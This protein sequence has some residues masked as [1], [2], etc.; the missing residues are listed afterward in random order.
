MLFDP[1]AR[2]TLD[3][4]TRLV[5]VI[6]SGIRAGGTVAD[7]AFSLKEVATRTG[8][9]LAQLEIDC[10]RDL[11]EHV[12]R[13]RTRRLT[14]LQVEALLRRHTRGGDLA[15]RTTPVSDAEEAR[16]MSLRN[17]RRGTR[18]KKS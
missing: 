18:W 12:H 8:F 14:S 11:I 16:Q 17:A 15:H 9:S 3:E 6:L 10:R 5:A 7:R 1:D 2:F 4:V 13:G